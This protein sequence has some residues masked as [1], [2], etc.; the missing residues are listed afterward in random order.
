LSFTYA[1]V[2]VYHAQSVLPSDGDPAVAESVD[3]VLRDLLDNS[4][5]L[6]A[7]MTLRVDFLS[8]GI[9]SYNQDSSA[10]VSVVGNGTVVFATNLFLG[11]GGGGGPK[12]L[13]VISETS[14]TGNASTTFRNASVALVS[15]LTT[16][17]SGASQSLVVNSS[18]DFNG[19][20]RV[21]GALTVGGVSNFTNDVTLGS[22][23]SDTVQVNGTFEVASDTT[24]ANDVVMQSTLTVAGSTTLGN[25]AS[26][27]LEVNG[28]VQINNN[29]R[30]EGTG[31]VEGNLS[32]DGDLDV[33]GSCQLGNNDGSDVIEVHGIFRTFGRTTLGSA[34]DDSL[35]INAT[36]KSP[37]AMSDAG[38]VP[39]RVGLL[40]TGS[41][42]TPSSGNFLIS[43]TSSTQ[44]FTLSDEFAE[45]DFFFVQHQGG[46]GVA[47]IQVPG[48]PTV[49]MSSAGRLAL[50]VRSESQW[51][52]AKWTD[53]V[54]VSP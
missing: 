27:S 43:A 40:T 11:S 39:F 8:P 15:P 12:N 53:N 9:R 18:S 23:V 48:Q 13:T 28:D 32:T 25:N 14:F 49:S 29:L 34:D 37:L 38:R 31:H 46:T 44:T 6:N 7:Q 17:G 35:F 10:F 26:D 20:T 21:D 36:L 3:V 42:I 50:L 41:A 47:N 22:S 54:T 2:P 30:V 19:P 45:G 51:Y 52:V 24:F 33:A 1:G 5:Y 16:V 4:A